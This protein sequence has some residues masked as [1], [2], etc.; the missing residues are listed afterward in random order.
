MP[1]AEIAALGSRSMQHLAGCAW[2]RLDG[3]SPVEYL[4][5]ATRR[6]CVRAL[7]RRWFLV[8]PADWREALSDAR[9]QFD[10]LP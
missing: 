7:C 9:R 3:K 4:S 5:D 1:P 2:A 8:G 6:E 10:G